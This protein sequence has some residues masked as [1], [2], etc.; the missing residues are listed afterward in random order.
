MKI[1]ISGGTGLIGSRLIQNLV[2]RGHSI[3]LFTSK[4]SL[5][6]EWKGMPI[7]LIPYRIPKG[8]DWEGIEAFVNLA[9]ENLAG[10]FWTK[11]TKERIYKSRVE[12]TK[13]IV[14]SILES[15]KSHSKSLHT[16][17]Q[18]SAVG[19]YG[20]F[21]KNFGIFDENSPKGEGFLSDLCQDWEDASKPLEK[22]S[23]RLAIVRI[24]IVL[25]KKGGALSK[26]LPVF[27]SFVGGPIGKGTQ[28]MSW[29]H[30]KD[31]IGILT[32]LLESKNVS[33]I[34]NACSPHPVS[35]EF[36]SKTFG[37]V[38]GRPAILKTPSLALQILFGEGAHILTKGQFVFPKKLLSFG[39]SF[40]FP[41]LK[42][43]LLDLIQNES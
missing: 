10:V 35:N 15:R 39:Y 37:E 20:F 18:A 34:F 1:G 11:N 13:N 43:A 41:E 29:I 4:D 23:I 9:G 6:V 17:I 33:G 25:D 19:Y 32:F 42:P 26:L 27:Q 22:E 8:K 36:F 28:G 31:M 5:P 16:F 7:T 14:N 30:F 3:L 21:E 38:L 2:A 12:H 40:S 24:G